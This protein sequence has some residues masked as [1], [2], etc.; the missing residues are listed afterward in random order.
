MKFKKYYSTTASRSRN[1]KAAEPKKRL[2]SKNVASGQGIV[3]KEPLSVS[4]DSTLILAA[5]GIHTNANLSAIARTCSCFRVPRI[6]CSGQA[7]RLLPKIAR[8]AKERVEIS[9]HNSLA[10]QLAKHKAAGYSIVALEQAANA[11]SIFD[12]KF[13]KK[14]ILTVGNEKTGVSADVLALCDAIVE[15]PIYALPHSLNVAAAASIGIYEYSKQHQ[16][17]LSSKAKNK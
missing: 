14:C 2:Q 11:L 15:I 16:F 10:H 3:R 6:I 1:L 7:G 5:A 9:H 12:F 8:D 4:E 13:P 17:L